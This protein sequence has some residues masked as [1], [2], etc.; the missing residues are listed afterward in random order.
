M[1][2]SATPPDEPERWL[3]I[4]GYEGFY[5]VSD[6]GR[7]RSVLHQTA[8]GPRGGRVLRPLDCHG[9]AQVS[10]SR[11]GVVRKRQVHKLVAEAFL[12]PCPIGQ[13]VCHG[14]AGKGDNRATELRYDT[15]VENHHDRIRDRTTSRGEKQG[16]AKLT[17]GAVTEIRRRAATG[18]TQRELA[19]EFGVCFQNIHLI[20]ARKTWLF[21]PEKW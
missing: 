16:A 10:L 8:K 20:V 5:E 21:P 3:P 11:Y 17:W 9:Y 15:H 4:R 12:G 14:P 1:A 13:E 7:V 19:T 6:L 2:E 18:E